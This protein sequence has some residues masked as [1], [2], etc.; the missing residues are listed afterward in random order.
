M[1]KDLKEHFITTKYIAKIWRAEGWLKEKDKEKDDDQLADSIARRF[2]NILIKMGFNDEIQW[3]MSESSNCGKGIYIFGSKEAPELM[4]EVMDLFGGERGKL[5][6]EERGFLIADL[7]NLLPERRSAK[8]Y[9]LAVKDKKEFFTGH[10]QNKSP[11]HQK[12]IEE[13][14]EKYYANQ[15]LEAYREKIFFR[16]GGGKLISPK[17]RKE[18]YSF[19]YEKI[20]EWYQKWNFI[21]QNVGTVKM[22]ERYDHS[23]WKFRDEKVCKKDRE[24][25]YKTGKLDNKKI[26]SQLNEEDW[27]S[28]NDFCESMS[29]LFSDVQTKESQK[30]GLWR[31]EELIEDIDVQ[32]ENEATEEGC[33][34][35]C[36][37]LV[38]KILLHKLKEISCEDFG[39]IREE[40]RYELEKISEKVKQK[41]FM[42]TYSEEFC[43]AAKEDMEKLFQIREMI[44]RIHKEKYSIEMFNLANSN[45]P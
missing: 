33:E 18:I 43:G 21:M 25:Y 40:A 41:L 31:I 7:I 24:A 39:F 8:A 16:I 38:E 42:E 5:T 27:I 22:V 36:A 13:L 26:N 44:E 15:E 6:V 20:K 30:S 9:E 4:K 34:I 2:K 11:D 14:V 3:Y 1:A 10:G 19:Q 35:K 32:G 12:R 45:N 23:F 37:N 17:V 29:R 28:K